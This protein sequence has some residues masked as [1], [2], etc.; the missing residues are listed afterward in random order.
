MFKDVIDGVNK[1]IN[2][3]GGSR[4]VD[5]YYI[6]DEQF[7]RNT[8]GDGVPKVSNVVVLGLG[9]IGGHVAEILGS[10]KHTRYMYLIDDDI[11]E[12]SNLNRSIYTYGDVSFSKV[13]SAAALISGRNVGVT[14]YP[15]A[16]KFNQDFAREFENMFHKG[17]VS[18][19]SGSI[20]VYDCRDNYYPE[21]EIYAD[22]E[23][24]LGC[25]IFVLR[26]AYNETSITIDLDPQNHPVWGNPGY[27]TVPSHSLPSRLAALLVCIF[28]HYYMD[29]KP[30]VRTTPMTFEMRDIVDFIF[31]GVKKL[32][33]KNKKL[34]EPVETT[35]TIEGDDMFEDEI[36][37]VEG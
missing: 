17:Q 30:E 12:L 13:E 10:M 33:R 16:N 32:N 34:E 27:T 1:T 19:T 4:I 2:Y 8:Q 28:G 15:F 5:P 24:G 18:K 20:M 37:E 3:S 36:E 35:N 25:R 7:V 26:A 6:M 23:K 9:G 22:L 29:L 31:S 14:V 21:K 11:V